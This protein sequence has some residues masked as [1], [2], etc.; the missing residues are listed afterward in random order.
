M[1]LRRLLLAAVLWAQSASGASVRYLSSEAEAFDRRVV[2]ELESVGFVV[3]QPAS[4][5]VELPEDCV[6]IVRVS[7]GQVEVWLNGDDGLRLAETMPRDPTLD[8]DSV[9]IAERLR[10]LLAPLAHAPEPHGELPP[11]PPPIPA[12]EPEPPPPEPSAPPPVAPP[13]RLEPP[14]DRDWEAGAGVAAASQPGGLGTAAAVW[15]RRRVVGHAFGEL[16]GQWPL[17]SSRIE[18]GTARADVD[19]RLLSASASY[20]WLEEPAW[21]LRSGVGATFAWVEARGDAPSPRRAS[22][23]SAVRVLPHACADVAFRLTP[24]IGLAG[25]VM[26]GYAPAKL[27]I[28]FGSDVVGTWGRPLLI[29]FAGVSFFP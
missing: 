11:P 9:R 10:G 29:G 1:K 22:D 21:T 7:G 4:E 14:P 19:A 8:E 20:A 5:V 23:E 26:L 12:P 6:A 24:A 2:A 27:D 15:L 18:R 13:P 25:G 16:V 28:A 3:D 17:T